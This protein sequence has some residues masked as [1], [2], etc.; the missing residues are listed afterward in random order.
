MLRDRSRRCM[1]PSE[2]TEHVT[3][4]RTTVATVTTFKDYNVTIKT[5]TKTDHG[6]SLPSSNVPIYTHKSGGAL[7]SS[8]NYTAHK[9]RRD[10]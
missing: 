10:L 7:E 2:S 6:H 5:Y 9:I 3:A 4:S 1:K 8:Y